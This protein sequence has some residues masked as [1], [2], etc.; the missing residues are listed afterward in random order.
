M[1]LT[2][3]LNKETTNS[4]YIQEWEKT[5]LE[6]QFSY[7]SYNRKYKQRLV[8]SISS[9]NK[10]PSPLLKPLYNTIYESFPILSEPLGLS[11]VRFQL[12]FKLFILNPI[13]LFYL[14]VKLMLLFTASV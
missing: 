14:L 8:Q 11:L 1:K 5:F 9:G 3:P 6:R 2:G 10:R 4:D 7:D 12:F 13:G